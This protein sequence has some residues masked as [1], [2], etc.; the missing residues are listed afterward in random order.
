MESR[1]VL[2][3]VMG[4][5]LAAMFLAVFPS[6]SGDALASAKVIPIEGM[7][8]NVDSSMEDNL[9]SL[10][11]KHVYVTIDKGQTLA[12]IL[13]AVGKNL[14]HLEKLDGKDF[15]DAMIRIEDISAIEAKFRDFER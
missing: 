14:I 7:A 1:K 10:V 5:T 3:G 9:K 11:G 2:L 4:I 6:L 15:F 13:K 8:Y 12:G